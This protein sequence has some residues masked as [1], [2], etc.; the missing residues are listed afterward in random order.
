MAPFAGIPV[1][2]LSP[3]LSSSDHDQTILKEK[4]LETVK[5]ACAEY[6]FFQIIN[7]GV[8]T[9][10]MKRALQLSKTFFE[11]PDEEKRK[12]SSG[13]GAP[14]PAGYNRQPLHSA[15][16]NEYLLVFPPQ[17]PFNVYPT[18]P[19]E[20]REVVEEV[21]LHMSKTA[22]LIESIVNDCLGLPPGFLQKFNSDRT[23]DF[24]SPLRYF[25]ATDSEDNGITPHEDGNS[26]TFV[27]Q[28]DAGGLEVLRGKDWIPATPSPGT[29][30]VNIGD[31]IQ[32]LSNNKF[33]SATHRV[34]RPKGRS[35]YSYAFF[36]SLS[37]EKFV[38]PLPEFTSEVGELPRYRKFQYRE[39]LQLRLRNKTHPPER[40]EDAIH[41]THYSIN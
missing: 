18:H 16:K 14:L 36:Y 22:S 8:P 32:V 11:L 29:I 20:L 27:F 31:V 17:S 28:D 1:V 25:P 10:L 37:G 7:H 35:R 15:D 12:F 2:D 26:V 30:V 6:G 5:E 38:E 40:P 34:V 24:M 9:E 13:D 23:W 33:K 4:V 41:I 3:F 21:F 39:Y 19:P